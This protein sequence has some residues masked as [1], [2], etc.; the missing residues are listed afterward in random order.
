L[1]QRHVIE[2]ETQ[3]LQ[4]F[5]KFKKERGKRHKEKWKGE[6]HFGISKCKVSN[7][8]LQTQERRRQHGIPVKYAQKINK[9]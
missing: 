9:T 4:Y 3:H 2:R 6:K 7:P 5:E 8:T 1:I